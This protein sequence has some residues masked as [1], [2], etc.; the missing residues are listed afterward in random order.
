MSDWI[1]WI[2]L[3]GY[4]IP[5]WHQEHRSRAMLKGKIIKKF[6]VERLRLYIVK[7]DF[8]VTVETSRLP[9]YVFYICPLIQTNKNPNANNWRA[10]TTFWTKTYRLWSWKC[11]S[12]FH[13][14]FVIG[15]IILK[16]LLGRPK[17]I[18]KG[19]IW[20]ETFPP[21]PTS[22]SKYGN[23]HCGLDR[24]WMTPLV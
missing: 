21:T 23:I 4:P 16:V 7:G 20:D 13:K 24:A 3:D 18:E 19:S 9:C 15:K 12:A 8:W 11:V 2:G 10:T 14:L 6:C 17:I 1:G 22:S 5:L